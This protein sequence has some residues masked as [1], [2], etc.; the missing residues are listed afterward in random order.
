MTSVHARLITKS[1]F[2]HY[3]EEWK[4]VCWALLRATLSPSKFFLQGS[5]SQSTWRDS[6]DFQD[7]DVC[8]V[9]FSVCWCCESSSPMKSRKLIFLPTDV[10]YSATLQERACCCSNMLR[11][12]TV[13]P[14]IRVV[15]T[16]ITKGGRVI[17]A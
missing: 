11:W 2:H 9:P 8:L 6:D 15:I 3:L 5:L 16:L 10:K 1:V 17:K 12:H 13:I 7:S 14:L 4:D